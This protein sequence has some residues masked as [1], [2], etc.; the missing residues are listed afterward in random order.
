LISGVAFD[1]VKLSFQLLFGFSMIRVRN[2]T[3]Y[4]A[5]RSTLRFIEIANTLSTLVRIDLISFVTGGDRLIGA[6][7]FAGTAINTFFCDFIGHLF[8]LLFRE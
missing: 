5:D 7:W 2:A 4:R 8:L 3:I 6:F 1:L